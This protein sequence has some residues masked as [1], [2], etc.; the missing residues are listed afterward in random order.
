MLMLMLPPR[1]APY[2]E[3]VKDQPWHEVREKDRKAA[4]LIKEIGTLAG[5]KV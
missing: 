5:Q 3:G 1:P 2:T 4:S